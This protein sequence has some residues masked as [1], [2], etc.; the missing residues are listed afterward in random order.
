[1]CE[2]KG[3]ERCGGV[4]YRGRVGVFE[5]IEV[6]GEVREHVRAGVDSHAIEAA[7]ARSGMTTMTVDA[8]EKAR[9]GATSAAEAIR[10]AAIR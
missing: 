10:I 2:P 1:V 9:A 6:A 8:V 5:A 7:A 3:C 4:G